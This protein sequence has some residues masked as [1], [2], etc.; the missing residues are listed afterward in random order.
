MGIGVYGLGYVGAVSV[1]GLAELGHDVVGVDINPVK[2][3]AILAGRSPVTEPGVEELLARHV[4]SGRITATTDGLETAA[5]VDLMMLAVGTPSTSSGGVDGRHLLTATNQI[6]EGIRANPRPFVAVVNRSTSLPAVHAELMAELEATSGRALGDGI[7][8]ACHPEFLREAVGLS[9]FF[10]PPVVVF[11]TDSAAT[12]TLCRELYPSLEA[13]V[14]EVGVGEAA[15]VKYASNCWHAAKVTFANEIG[16]L[17]HRQGIDSSSVMDIFCLDDKL[18]ISTKYLR[19]GSPFGGSCLPKDLRAV[20]D[21]ARE[22]A[23]VV[24][25]LQATLLSN[26]D[27]IEAL[28]DRILSNGPSRVAVIGFAFKEGTDDLREAPMVPV[29]ERLIGKGVDVAIYDATLAVD[30][31]VGANA[32]YALA[33]VPHLADLVSDDITAVVNEADVIVVSHRLEGTVDWTDVAL[34]AETS[35]IDTVGVGPLKSHPGYDGL[36]WPSASGN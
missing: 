14:I 13:D 17:C 31:L 12:T 19:P 30:E 21:A 11:G 1:A 15:M 18:N 20:L 8:Y 4:G 36:F 26:H 6:A 16:E 34:P 9:D 25:M 3:E 7:G 10:D 29:V 5:T 22:M 23:I 24:P 2:V 28:A 33:T 32:A 27:Q 35:I